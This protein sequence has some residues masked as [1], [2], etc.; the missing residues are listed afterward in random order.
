MSVNGKQFSFLELLSSCKRVVIPKIQRD[1]AQGRI[2]INNDIIF[3]KEV[4]DMFVGSISNA[5]INDKVL[6][7]DYIYGS[8]DNAEFFYPIDG[9]QRLTTLFLLYWYIGTKE[10]KIDDKMKSELKKFSYEIRDTATE[11]CRAL[12]EISFDAKKDDC[13]KKV[14]TNS[15]K[16]FSVYDNDPTI[17]AML[18]MIEKIHKEFQNMGS[19]WD[20]LR[21]ITFWALSLE[22]FGLTDDLFV[23]MN[24]RGKRLSKFDTFK[25]DLELALDKNSKDYLAN[26]DWIQVIDQ[27]KINIDNEYL[28]KFWRKYG[29]DKAERNIFRLIIFL[30][31]SLDSAKYINIDFD[32]TW[33]QNDLNTQ[34]GAAIATIVSDV[35]ILKLICKTLETFDEWKDTDPDFADLLLENKEATSIQFHIKVKFFGI[36]YWWGTIDIARAKENF[37]SFYRILNNFVNSVREPNKRDRQY[38]S[39]IDKK[40]IGGR[41]KFIK[42]IIDDFSNQVLPFYDFVRNSEYKE[43]S[44]ERE[45]LNYSNID[46][47]I[48]LEK[49]PVLNT[50]IHNLFFNGKIYIEANELGCII[51]DKNY[52]NYCLRI[53]LSFADARYGKFND[54]VFDSTSMQSGKRQLYYDSDTDLATGYCHK[55]FIRNVANG[56]GDKVLTSSNFPDQQEA[57]KEFAKAFYDKYYGQPVKITIK[58]V[59]SEI[60]KDR[61]NEANFSDME[62]I[63]WYI[64]KYEEF[65]YKEDETT[66]LVLR[67]KNYGS[68]DDDN[69]YDIR[70]TNENFYIYEPHYQPFYLALSQYLKKKNSTIRIDSK[71]L[72]IETNQIEYENPCK[73]S[74][75]WI[76]RIQHM[77]SWKVEF[78][79]VRPDTAIIT[80]YGI[81]GDSFVLK[82]N[83]ADCI[84]L[85]GDFIIECN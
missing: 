79:G 83:S 50:Q 39:S 24:A 28:D 84:E 69:V 22:N 68:T 15:S 36:V 25:S 82:N 34:Y 8:K 12:I 31:K 4:R 64:V 38:N 11:F 71:I 42:V 29:Q 55:Y 2:D 35:K 9:Q 18:V 16:Y 51:A 21:N 49:S 17:Q 26:K 46:K 57:V 65:F 47:I 7:L 19:L 3:Y 85:I 30:V 41:L 33:E 14:I 53:I 45:K 27:W 1:Y 43:M 63:Q 44:F 73:L 76:I 72:K 6:V 52:K 75:G 56:F 48:E 5:L 70:C 20:K 60:L 32:D 66:F 37:L 58:E 81:I 67:R 54:L 23:K 61:L 78:N 80:K 62:S 40:S 13:I 77:G 74:N 59:L 10:K